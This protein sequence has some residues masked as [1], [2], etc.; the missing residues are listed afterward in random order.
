MSNRK[1]TEILAELQSRGYET[2]SSEKLGKNESSEEDED[3]SGISDS[4]LAKGYDYLLG[5]K[6]WSLTFEKAEKLLEELAV[7]TTELEE[8]EATSPSQIWLNDLEAIDKAL[9][10][11]DASFEAAKQEELNA[12]AKNQKHRA[13]TQRKTQK[14]PSGRKKAQTRDLDEESSSSDIIMGE[15]AA[16]QNPRKEATNKKKAPVKEVMP[17][18]PLLDLTDS[19]DEA[20]SIG[21]AERI[22]KRLHLSVNVENAVESK[23]RAA[24]PVLEESNAGSSFPQR[25]PKTQQAKMGV[26][27][28]KAAPV[29]KSS[30]QAKKRAAASKIM[31]YEDSS[32]SGDDFSLNSDADPSVSVSQPNR[33]RS[34]RNRKPVV[35]AIDGDSSDESLT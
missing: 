33:S 5:M 10:D 12:Q 1:Q 26:P 15:T 31:E 20:E 21:L 23:K 17:S 24:S 16:K 14:K 8:L 13:K 18:K 2:F 6:I 30:L 29:K 28:K 3:E 25:D 35:Y 9:D 19:G 11:R 22:Q 32:D 7:K 34:A 4:A 27:P